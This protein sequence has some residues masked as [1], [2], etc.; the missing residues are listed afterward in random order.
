LQCIIWQ[1][2]FAK[3]D[4]ELR[5]GMLIEVS[6]A[7]TV[8]AAK[9]KMNFNVRSLRLAGEGDLRLKVAQL[10]KKLEAEGLMEHWRKQPLPQMPLKVAVVTSPHGKAVHDVLRTLRRRYPIAEVLVAGVP[11]EGND[12]P[13][14][15]I[16]GLEVA[17][18]AGP[19]VILLV[20]GGGS[21]EDL[22]PFNDEG[23][24]QAV[25]ACKV[26][27]VTG[28]GHEPDT[29]IAD[30][31]SDRRASTP[32][33]AAEAVTPDI[34]ELQARLQAS[35]AAMVQAL[36]SQVG[37]MRSR[38][39][40]LQGNRVFRDAGYVFASAGMALEQTAMRLEQALPNRL[41]HDRVSLTN[42]QQRLRR[43]AASVLVPFKSQVGVRAAKLESLSPLA[44]LARGY[45]VAYDSKGAVVGSI[46][47]VDCGDLLRIALAD[48]YLG[49]MVQ[50][51]D[52]QIEE[53]QK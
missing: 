31:V 15:I 10:A 50:S 39:T 22:M 29:T 43:V 44:V 42:Q 14:R 23:L 26:P 35:E 47:A 52:K 46:D 3:F 51:K 33:A 34:Q 24:A 5:Q 20:R 16:Q 2:L 18:A 48:G 36:R 27:V 19:D 21:Y 17:A 9:G 49:C 7:F 28:I 45:S 30:M 25:A 53:V 38:V 41:E 1:N 32:T 11:V 40:A 12:A 6:G 13:A 37:R 8:Y 4:I